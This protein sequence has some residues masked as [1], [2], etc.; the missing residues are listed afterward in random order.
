MRV[1]NFFL[2]AVSGTNSGALPTF[3]TPDI[4]NSEIKDGDIVFSGLM[5]SG[6]LSTNDPYGNVEVSVATRTVSM[7]SITGLSF[8]KSEISRGTTDRGDIIVIAAR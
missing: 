2:Y 6:N 7:G 1:R 8:S 5:L 4:S 3:S